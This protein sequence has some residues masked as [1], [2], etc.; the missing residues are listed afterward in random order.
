MLRSSHTTSTPPGFRQR[1]RRG[2]RC[3]RPHAPRAHEEPGAAARLDIT[4]RDQTDR[5]P[6]P[7]SNGSP[8]FRPRNAGSTAD[9]CRGAARVRRCAAPTSAASSAAN[10]PPIASLLGAIRAVEEAGVIAKR[11]GQC[12]GLISEL[13]RDCIGGFGT[14]QPSRWSHVMNAVTG[15][16]PPP[17]L[18]R[19][20]T[21]IRT[22]I[23]REILSVTQ[24]PDVISLA[25]GLPSPE[26]FPVDACARRSTGCCAS[27][28]RPRCSTAPPK[29]TRRCANGSRVTKPPA[30]RR[31]APIRCSSCRVRNRRSISSARY[32]SIRR[33][34]AGGSTVLPGALQAFAQ[35]AARCVAVP[36]TRTA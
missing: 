22:S 15:T 23:L 34:R 24:Q 18:A 12:L 21:R 6:R 9:A 27:T 17:P 3:R 5:R 30:A 32:S 26:C 36:R 20:A 29:A 7:P 2:A 16:Y 35:Y 25:G 4:G 13:Y 31:R 14:L 33:R 1:R 8:A 28:A 19:R 11:P 10:V